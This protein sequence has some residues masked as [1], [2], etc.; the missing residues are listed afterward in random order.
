MASHINGKRLFIENL[1]RV[2]TKAPFVRGIHQLPV[3]SHIKGTVCPIM[4]GCGL[5]D[6]T[7]F[8]QPEDSEATLRNAD[9]CLSLCW[10]YKHNKEKYT[11]YV[12][13]FY[14]KYHSILVILGPPKQHICRPLTDRPKGPNDHTEVLVNAYGSGIHTM[15]VLAP[16]SWKET[17]E[18]EIIMEKR[19]VFGNWI[20]LI[21]Y[22]EY[23]K[24]DEN[25]CFAM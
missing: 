21:W 4:F 18:T 11:E 3:D 12:C 1:V 23:K 17:D 7:T 25:N 8:L 22:I 13:M 10:Q 2:K 9:K 20:F 15:G 19:P 5:V 14:D 24:F 6:S 16:A